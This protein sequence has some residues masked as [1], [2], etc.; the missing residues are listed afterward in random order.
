MTV[1]DPSSSYLNSS[2]KGCD[3]VILAC[4]IRVQIQTDARLR[5]LLPVGKIKF[6]LKMLAE[7]VG[8][9]VISL[10]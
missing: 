5:H 2:N 10:S 9:L 8:K 1:P 3:W 7:C 6:G 4:F